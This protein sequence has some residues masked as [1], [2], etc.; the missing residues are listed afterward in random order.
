MHPR[1]PSPSRSLHDGA[2]YRLTWGMLVVSAIISL[3]ECPRCCGSLINP[4]QGWKLRKHAP[5]SCAG[6]PPADQGGG[7]GLAQPARGLVSPA[8]ILEVAAVNFPLRR[9]GWPS[10]KVQTQG[11]VSLGPVDYGA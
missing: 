10:L 1:W 5:L 2:S 8:C 6:T 9:L 7:K 4:R 3:M 11:Y